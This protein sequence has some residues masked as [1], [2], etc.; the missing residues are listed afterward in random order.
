M[1]GGELGSCSDGRRGAEGDAVAEGFAL[2]V[3]LLAMVGLERQR[4]VAEGQEVDQGA[5]MEGRD[6]ASSTRC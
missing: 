6:G 4:A 2:L 1:L 5:V 3:R